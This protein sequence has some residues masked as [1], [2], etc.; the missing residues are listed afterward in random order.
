MKTNQKSHLFL[1]LAG[2]GWSLISP[3]LGYRSEEMA[4]AMPLQTAEQQ[5]PN[6]TPSPQPA[7][8]TN[9]PNQGV[10][11]TPTQLPQ[12]TKPTTAAPTS[13]EVPNGINSLYKQLQSSLQQHDWG[14]VL[15]VLL[16][17]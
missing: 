8:N 16:L 1:L 4:L 17:F 9:E 10:T 12:Q 6:A 15:D 7:P 2:L 13:L 11:P 14:S 3:F 5:N